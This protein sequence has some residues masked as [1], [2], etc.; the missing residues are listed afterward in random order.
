M[1]YRLSV[2]K[3]CSTSLL[4]LALLLPG[5]RA[6]AQDGAENTL[7]GVEPPV[8]R[9]IAPDGQTVRIQPPLLREGGYLLR[10]PGEVTINSTLGVHQF[11][12]L[13]I[14]DGGI[15]RELILLPSRAMNDLVK[16]LALAEK[17]DDTRSM[18]YE[19]SGKVLVYRGRNFVLPQTVVQLDQTAAEIE[20]NDKP[21]AVGAAPPE[22][23]IPL[24][25]ES[26]DLAAAIEARLK[27]RI[28]AVPRSVDVASA[29]D[30]SN[31]PPPL[32]AGTRL[33]NR[34]G[35]LVRDP[36]SGTWRFVFDGSPIAPELLPCQ[37]LQRIENRTRQT[38]VPTPLLVSGVVTSF[39]GR[40]YLLPTAFREA[41]EGRGI[42]P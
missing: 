12:P 34:R 27:A 16:L 37:E 41:R 35:H 24:D 31:A 17:N 5:G 33:Q 18:V 32:R 1:D 20:E 2:A 7:P 3:T 4:L 10:E 13:K 28:G 9:R 15:R 42:G 36:S 26:D 25:P 21:D 14:E 23:E 11:R 38:A 8:R 30:A 22:E 29:S 6:S 19:V 39:H 40:N